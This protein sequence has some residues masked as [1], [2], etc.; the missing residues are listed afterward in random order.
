MQAKQFEIILVSSFGLLVGVL[1]II[2]TKKRWKFLVHPA[3]V[4]DIFYLHFGNREIL[5]KSLISFNYG[6]GALISVR[7]AIFIALAII[8]PNRIFTS[9]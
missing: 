7:A 8:N 3:E 6:L 4:W 2:G 1:L 5:G 9:N